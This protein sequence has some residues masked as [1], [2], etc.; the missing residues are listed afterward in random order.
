MPTKK[1]LGL[2]DLFPV[3]EASPITDAALA[4]AFPQLEEQAL[5]VV[6]DIGR[7]FGQIPIDRIVANPFQ[8]RR[9]FDS[10]KLQ[11]LADSLRDDGMLEPILVRVS[12]TQAD[13]YEIAAGERRWR[14]AQLAGMTTCPA[15]ILADCPDTKMRRIALLENLQREELTP[16]ELAETYGALMREKDEQG[17]PIYTV[18]GLAEMLKKDKGH[19]DDHLALMRVP[20]EVR[21]LIEEDAAIPVRVIRELGGVE[22]ANDR[23]YLI[24][25]VR[26]RNLK[27]ADLIAILQQQRARKRKQRAREPQAGAETQQQPVAQPSPALARAVLERKLQRYHTD[28]AKTV[29]RISKDLPTMSDEQRMLVRQYAMTWITELQRLLEAE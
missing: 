29:N 2:N 15:E 27:T 28:V 11:E 1:K 9:H 22:D 13:S 6:G 3:A 7:T 24:A 16:L 23:A 12:P 26:A 21:Q 10:Q 8:P 5:Q 19:V 14:A 18:R 17:K 4:K 25:E 20:G